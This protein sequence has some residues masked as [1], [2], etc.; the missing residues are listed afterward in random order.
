MQHSYF[1]LNNGFDALLIADDD[2]VMSVK[3]YLGC[4]TMFYTL[5][6]WGGFKC[7]VFR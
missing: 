7:N 3:H 4:F 5:C 2:D 1:N 6:I